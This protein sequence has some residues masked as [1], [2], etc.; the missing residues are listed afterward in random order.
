[1]IWLALPIVALV[2]YVAGVMRGFAFLGYWVE[3]WRNILA[4]LQ[5]G[6]GGWWRGERPLRSSLTR[7]IRKPRST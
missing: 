3:G 5:P 7:F 4:T 6:C 2:A 1:M